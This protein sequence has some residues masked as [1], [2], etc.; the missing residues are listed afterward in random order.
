MQPVSEFRDQ[1]YVG[2]GG[3]PQRIL[4]FSCDHVVPQENILPL[5]LHRG[6]TGTLLDF[7]FSNRTPKTMEE[8]G[9]TVFNLCN[10]IPGRMY[11]GVTPF[12]QG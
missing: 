7:S 1:L 3:D 12:G 5:V 9:R 11:R 10:V 6:P 4:N 2:S 8:M